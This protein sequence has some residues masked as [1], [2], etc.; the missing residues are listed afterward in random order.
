MYTEDF[1]TRFGAMSV[2]NKLKT[3]KNMETMGPPKTASTQQVTTF[4]ALKSW[5]GVNVMV[6][7]ELCPPTIKHL[8][9]YL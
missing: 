3:I 7:N 1:M 4:K 6:G 2:D 9:L 8:E 5:C